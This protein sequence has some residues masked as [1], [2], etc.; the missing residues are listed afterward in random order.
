[1]VDSSDSKLYGFGVRG[2]K[3]SQD[4][5]IGHVH[6]RHHG[7]PAFVIVPHLTTE[8]HTSVKPNLHLPLPTNFPAP[9]HLYVEFTLHIS[10]ERADFSQ[11]KPRV[12]A[13]KEKTC[14]KK[15]LP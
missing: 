9:D 7:V 11:C 15:T 1:M 2:Q 14:L 5:I 6:E 4:G 3:G 10:Q 13:L 12:V 8:C